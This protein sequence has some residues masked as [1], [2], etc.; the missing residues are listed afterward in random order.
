MRRGEMLVMVPTYNERGN[1]EDLCRQL[2]ALG[3]D[4][5]LLFVDDNSPDGTGEI[6]DGLGQAHPNVQVMHR[7]AKQG[8]GG[9]HLDGI[10]WAYDRGYQTLITM[11]CDFTHSPGDIP[12]ILERLRDCDVAVGSRFLQPGS[13]AGWKASRKALTLLGHF[14]TRHLLGNPY[15]TTGAF[16]AYRLS[17]IPREAFQLVRARG[18][19]FFLESL[20]ILYRNGL[21]IREFPINLPARTYGHSKMSLREVAR[22]MRRLVALYL[23]SRLNPGMFRVLEPLKE[24]N[25]QLVDPQGWD[26]YWQRKTETNRIVYDL[27]ASL[28]RRCVIRRRLNQTIGRHFRPGSSLLHAGCGGGQVDEDIQ[29]TMSLTAVDISVPALQLY[30]RNNPRAVG[31]KH[32]SILDLPF[33]PGSFDGVYNLGVMEHFTDQEIHKILCEFHRVLKPGGRVVVFW[34][35]ARA[36]SVYVLRAAHWLLNDVLG[37]NVHLHA[38]EISL[39]KSRGQAAALTARAGFELVEYCFGPQDFFVQAILVARKPDGLPP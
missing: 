27:I 23:E 7:P 22:S 8:I 21:V 11:D 6:L 28:Y 15:D 14:L 36:S 35:Y 5:D 3:L 37:K 31:V 30:R 24:T 4:A 29:K 32:A 38:P 1:V 25:P 2:L 34:P 10:A 33:A 12:R 17:R 18:Y 20:F 39:L 9:A 26:E 16:R 19:A 13:L